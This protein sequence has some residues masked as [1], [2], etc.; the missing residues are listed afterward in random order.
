MVVFT[1]FCSGVVDEDI[2]IEVGLIAVEVDVSDVVLFGI[3]CPVVDLGEVISVLKEKVVIVLSFTV[4]CSADVDVETMVKVVLLAEDI[5]CAVVVVATVGKLVLL[6]EDIFVAD[7]VKSDVVCLVVVIL[8][9]VS[10]WREGVF[11]VVIFKELCSAVVDAGI[12]VKVVLLAV[13]VDI[14]DVV[15]SPLIVL[16][17]VVSV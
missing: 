6:A 13:E 16:G 17:D 2:I 12:I 7:V 14:G 8:A 15:V 11:V 10:V 4:L 9:V 1:G 3:V 5:C